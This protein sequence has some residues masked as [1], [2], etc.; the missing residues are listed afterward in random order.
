MCF[1][2]MLMS[3]NGDKE[4][5]LLK[6]ERLLTMGHKSSFKKPKSKIHPRLSL[7]NSISPQQE[8]HFS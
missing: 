6:I 1:G 4:K 2:K 7:T 5:F 3:T 8:E